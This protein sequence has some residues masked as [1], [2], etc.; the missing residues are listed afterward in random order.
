MRDPETDRQVRPAAVETPTD[1]EP[2]TEPA[3]GS[4]LGRSFANRPLGYPNALV[5]LRA[6]ILRDWRGVLGAFLAT[7]F[8]VPVA[9]LLAVWGGVGL[10]AYGLVAGGSGFAD[11]V[12][13]VL[14]DA[15][16]VGALLDAFL[17]RSGGVL[18]GFAGFAI[19]FLAGFLVVLVLPWR[20]AFDEPANLFTG[21]A[22]M[23]AA[24]AL[25]GVLYT[26]Y[27]VLWEPW[28]LTVSG[29]RQLSR[30]E[31]ARLRPVLYDCASALGLPNVP[32]LLIEDD[33][34]LTNARAYA[35]HVV[36][37]TSLLDESDEDIAALL[38]H[39]LVHWHT[40]DEVTGAFVRGVALPLVLVHAVPAWLMRTF[41]HPATNLVVFVF[42]WPVLLTMKYVVLPPH[43]RD[44]RA[45]EYRADAGA[46]LAGHARGMRDMLERRK[47][48]ESGRSG[49][50]E[51]VCATHP[52]SELRLD[53]LELLAPAADAVDGVER[54][55]GDVAPVT[56]ED[57]FGRP[58][59]IA[60]PRAV[61]VAGVLA[62]ACGLGGTLLGA[63]QWA[64]FRPA[65]VVD[66]YFSGLADH[67]ARAALESLAP[68]VRPSGGD[69]ELLAALVEAK[70]YQPPEDVDVTS[71]ERD[72]D[73]AVATVDFTLAGR[74]TTAKLHLEREESATLGVFHGWGISESSPWLGLPAG[75]AGLTIN[76]VSVPAGPQGRGIS[77]LPGGYTVGGQ[78]NPLAETPP[79]VVLAVPGQEQIGDVRLEPTLTPTARSTADQEV[80]KYLD[81]CAAKQVAAPENC[82]FRYYPGET[83]KKIAWRITEY[84][85]VELTLT[86]PTTAQVS[87]PY[88]AQGTARATGTTEGFYGT[89][90]FTED[91]TFGVTGVLSVVDGRLTFQP[92]E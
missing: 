46:V 16:L 62:L 56:A 73:E 91:D 88:E 43:S 54:P 63:A 27:R 66:G 67:D 23:V 65:T 72:G 45:A 68:G 25:V 28:L 30:R 37:T 52:A 60:S 90:P 8:Y 20:D 4:R 77:L 12:P 49:W 31:A 33:P 86:G 36:V 80:R 89:S 15:P 5:W 18:G 48:F 78:S 17:N 2:A 38:S 92:G 71:I 87:T 59:A 9:L 29:A 85:K 3:D 51:A 55:A 42:F 34:V 6:G 40:G 24:A 82:P 14:R 19:G 64:F 83:V 11:A 39:E 61:L 53:R 21:L 47:S 35:R 26:L 58:G 13:S 81:A 70:D 84:P 22:G 76:G 41:P 32:R 7:W 75:Q 74:K 50:D 10:A 69:L 79:Q 1:P 44:V 57:L